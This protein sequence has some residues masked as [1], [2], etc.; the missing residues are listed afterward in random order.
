[1]YIVCLHILLA[2]HDHKRSHFGGTGGQQC[3][4]VTLYPTK[5]KDVFDDHRVKQ[6]TYLEVLE[7]SPLPHERIPFPAVLPGSL[8]H[9]GVAC[10]SKSTFSPPQLALVRRQSHPQLREPVSFSRE[11]PAIGEQAPGGRRDA[12][13]G[14]G[15][16]LDFVDNSDLD[17]T[18]QSRPPYPSTWPKTKTP[19][20]WYRRRLPPRQRP[21]L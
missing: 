21:P 16:G 20:T 19:T 5:T 3:L 4:R 15:E 11:Q 10:T 9:D 12:R 13:V 14:N 1:M 18:H 2:E 17:V 8:D 6:G 7:H